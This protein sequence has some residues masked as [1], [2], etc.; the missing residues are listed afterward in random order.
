MPG[1]WRPDRT[2]YQITEHGRTTLRQWLDASLSLA[3]CASDDARA[4]SSDT[5]HTAGVPRSDPADQTQRQKAIV[6]LHQA[7]DNAWNAGDADAFAARWTEDGTVVSPLGQASVGRAAIRTDE[8]AAFNGPMKGTRHKLTVSHMYWP[9]P[10]IVVI[11]GDAE[12]S[13]FRDDGGAPQPPLT[14]KFTS[15]CVQQQGKWFIS[16]LRSYVY[17][18]P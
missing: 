11:D 17:L 18:K 16:H 12:I 9:E 15:V 6:E 13:G 1:P 3:G 7:L 5:T 2:I 4:P 14:A 8:A 10:N